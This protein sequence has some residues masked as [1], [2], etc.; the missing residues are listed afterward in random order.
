[1]DIQQIPSV[2]EMM[3]WASEVASRPEDERRA[4]TFLD[5]KTPKATRRI[6]MDLIWRSKPVKVWLTAH[7]SFGKTSHSFD[8]PR[9][10]LTSDLFKLD[11][12]VSCH[13]DVQSN[14][15]PPST[16]YSWES[17][18]RGMD[19]YEQA[20]RIGVYEYQGAPYRRVDRLDSKTKMF[21]VIDEG[22]FKLREWMSVAPEWLAWLSQAYRQTYAR[23]TLNKLIALRIMEQQC[24]LVT[25]TML[26]TYAQLER[27][28]EFLDDSPS[29][30]VVF[31]R[32]THF[33]HRLLTNADMRDVYNAGNPSAEAMRLARLSARFE[34]KG[35]DNA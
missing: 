23:A 28:G 2:A 12:V 4:E 34:K 14:G 22:I 5:E 25:T 18:G 19:T 30:E 27:F 29:G 31:A 11:K 3:A 26:E 1:M 15:T 8:A 9:V 16:N 13:F 21:E 35:N 10:R 17:A 32:N 7:Y 20:E 24:R 6:D 33:E